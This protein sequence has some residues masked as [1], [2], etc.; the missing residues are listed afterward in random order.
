MQEIKSNS[1]SS[2]RVSVVMPVRNALP[3]LDASIA[4]ILTQS[5][6]DFEFI[7]GDDG[8]TDGSRARLTEWASRDQRIKVF[9]G[10]GDGLGPV[11]SSNW[12]AGLATSPLV[13]RM[14]ADDISGQDRLMAQVAALDAD[15]SAILVGSVFNCIDSTGK[16]VRPPERHHLPDLYSKK[17]PFAHGSIMYRRDAF[18]VICGYRQNCDFWEDLELYWRIAEQ[19]RL[20]VLP[21]AHYSYRFNQGHSRMVTQR[22]KVEDALD[23]ML[24][25]CA[26]RSR[27][28]SYESL[29]SEVLPANRKHRAAVFRMMGQMR[30]SSG[31]RP[32]IFPSLLSRGR[33]LFNRETVTTILWGLWAFTAPSTLRAAAKRLARN[34]ESRAVVPMNVCYEWRPQRRME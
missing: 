34:R 14:D 10:E 16:L 12:V 23:L 17:L 3:F 4:S 5:F 8:S 28:E 31:G 20:L 25:C 30:L 33:L 2:P 29:L 13:A 32:N 6:T 22:R 1:F 27:G 19:G 21:E 11:G 15:P 24:R 9:F 7:I 18:E 26:A